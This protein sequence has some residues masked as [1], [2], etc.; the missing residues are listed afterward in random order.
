MNPRPESPEADLSNA[1]RAAMRHLAGAVSILTTGEGADRRGLTASSLTSFA[2]DPPTLLICVNRNSSARPELLGRGAFAVNVLRPEQQRLAEQFAGV[3]GLK[4]EER[5]AGGRWTTL[6]TGAPVLEDALASFDCRLD[7]VIE[8]HSH[9]IVLG[10]VVAT[11]LA[12]QAEPLI[13][14]SRSF[15]RLAPEGA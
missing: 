6:V 12:E 5:F 2:V 4:G 9:M 14:W 10:R 13:Y 8:R 3:G 15:R 11:R 7:E 1:Y